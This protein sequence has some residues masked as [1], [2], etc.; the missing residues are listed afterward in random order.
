LK[1][2][3]GTEG[4][5]VLSTWYDQSPNQNH[6]IQGEESAKPLIV[7]NQ[8]N[9]RPIARFDGSNDMMSLPNVMS[10]ATAGEII[11]VLKVPEPTTRIN[12]LWHFGTGNGSLYYAGS[13]YDDFGSSNGSNFSAP[14]AA[15]L[16]QFH[17]Y[18]V[19][20]NSGLWI[21]RLNGLERQRRTGQTLAFRSDP[22]IGKRGN[23]SEYLKGDIAE[24]L[25]YD[26]ALTDAERESANRYLT[27][28]YAPP[29]IP[30]P[31]APTGL[32]AVALASN[33]VNL[34]WTIA[35]SSLRTTATIER[36]SGGGSFEVVAIKE[37]TLEFTDTPPSPGTTYTYRVKLSSLAGSSAYSSEVSALTL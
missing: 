26:R 8:I 13:R 28:K 31:A 27:A 12:A 16:S 33:Q 37:N 2:D 22:L 35:E 5:G 19:S 23:A 25:V 10:G 9:G 1:A 21:E 36:K 7:A 32:R 30:V 18:N 3:Q 17:Y 14:P 4:V 15:S 20:M 11:A 29:A 6:A 34:A 24:I